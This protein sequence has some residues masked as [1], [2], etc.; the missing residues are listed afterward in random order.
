MGEELA[1]EVH[2]LGQLVQ[3]RHGL[4]EVELHGLGEV[5]VDVEQYGLGQLV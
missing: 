5:E 4:G 1:A 3:S 2:G